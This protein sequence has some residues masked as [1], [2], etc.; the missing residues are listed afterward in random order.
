M[1][2][3]R[4]PLRPPPERNALACA[5]L[6]LAYDLAWRLARG[7]P[8]L[9]RRLGGVD[10]VIQTACLALVR[11]AELWDPARGAFAA[12]AG[13]CMRGVILQAARAA[14]LIRVPDSLRRGARA[15][16]RR[17]L[18]VARL[19]PAGPPEEG[20][21]EP[22][23]PPGPDLAE[24]E[25]RA[26]LLGRLRAALPGLPERERAAVLLCDLGGLRQEEAG[27]RL[28]CS[29]QW[30]CALR[31]QARARLRGLLVV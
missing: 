13:A 5:N 24:A 7:R 9:V 8:A 23:A 25:E 15:A 27:R 18:R 21:P 20:V 11:A 4:V 14:D 12:Y 30:V 29:K 31:G 19:A 1:A 10:D 3:S 17:R 16:A 28:G 22:A 6:R 2:A 26:A